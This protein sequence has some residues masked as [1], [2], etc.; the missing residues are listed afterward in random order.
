MD[1]LVFGA[2]KLIRGFNKKNMTSSFDAGST[3]TVEI[4]LSKILQESSL[5][6][7]QFVD[8]CILC[9][10]DYTPKIEK[11]GPVNALKLIKELGGI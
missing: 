11:I 1:T 7:A 6:Y 10:C 4:T 8:F 2:E 3:P 5:S 9:G